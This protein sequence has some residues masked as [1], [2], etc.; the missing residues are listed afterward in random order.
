MRLHNVGEL[1]GV[2]QHIIK[3]RWRAVSGSACRLQEPVHTA[4]LSLGIQAFHYLLFHSWVI[5]LLLIF[6]HLKERVK[7]CGLKGTLLTTKKIKNVDL[8][9]MQ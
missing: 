6:L 4:D 8:E 3:N 1:C 7:L 9:R 2:Q 5:P